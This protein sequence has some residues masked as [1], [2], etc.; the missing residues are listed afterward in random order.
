MATY[1]P[2]MNLIERRIFEFSIHKWQ[3]GEQSFRKKDLEE[4]FGNIGTK[5][6]E[7]Q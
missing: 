3:I 6:Y 7:N 2:L 4:L 1:N 5:K